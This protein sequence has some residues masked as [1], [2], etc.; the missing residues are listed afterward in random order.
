MRAL[1]LLTWE[2]AWGWGGGGMV[3]RVGRRGGEGMVGGGVRRMEG[4]W[5]M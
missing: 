2:S 5:G 3:G 4:W 1:G